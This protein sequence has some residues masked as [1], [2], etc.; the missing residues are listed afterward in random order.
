MQPPVL[1][2]FLVEDYVGAPVWFGRFL[3]ILNTFMESTVRVLNKNVSF[4]DNIQARAF[5]T[6]FQTPAAYATGSFDTIS[7]NWTGSALPVACLI[8][9]ITREDGTPFLDSVGTP[10]WRFG[11]GN[12]QIAYIPGLTAGVR[13]NVSLL[14]F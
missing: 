8:T 10:Q 6:N 9:R 5:S 14:A 4:G 13:Y 12:I 11:D 3:Q 7:F 1:K 2:R